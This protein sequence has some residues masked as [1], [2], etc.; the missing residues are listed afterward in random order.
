MADDELLEELLTV[1][2]RET[3]QGLNLT[4]EDLC[5]DR[6][7]LARELEQ[8]IGELPQK[9]GL[10][11]DAF[12]TLSCANLDSH[13]EGPPP[14]VPSAPI[15]PGYEV[16]GELGRGG[17]GVVYQARQVKLG[18]VVALKMILSGAHAGTADLARFRTEAEA[19]ARLQHP[20]IVQIY[21]V[22]EY[23]GQPFFSLEFCASG[24]LEKKLGRTP[25]PPKEAAALVETLARAMQTAHDKGVIHRDLKPANV[26]LAEDGT[27]KIT[28]F[29]LAKKLDEVGQTMTGAV[30]GTPPYMAPEQAGG[31][32]GPAGPAV[33]VYAL[34]AILYE[35]L[36]GRPPFKAATSIDTIMQVLSH[37]PVPPRQL[38]P[39]TP[40][41]LETVCLKCLQK[42][43][44]KRYASAH[45]L[46]EDLRRFQ[47]DEPILARPVGRAE[48]GWRWCR[49]NPAV[50]ASLVAVAIA[51][52]A[53]S[54]VSVSF[55]LRAAERARTESA[56]KQDAERAHRDAQRQ[57][58]DLCVGSG[59][60]AAKENDHGLALLW[61][62]RATQLAKDEPE[63]EELNRIRV[64]NWLRQVCLPEGAFTVPG[65]RERE[66]KFRTFQFS[67]DGNYLLVI[68]TSAGCQ[69]WD[70]PA[71][72]LVPLPEPAAKSAAAAWQ[73]KSGLLA[74]AGGDGQIRL[75]AP[76]ELRPVGEAITAGEATV[77]AFSQDGQRLAWGGPE[78]AR[79][80]D[81]GRMDYITP[82]L[83][84]PAPVV[85]VAFS[86]ASELLATSARDGK[87]RVFR[88]GSAEEKPLFPPVNHFLGEY[89]NQTSDEPGRVPP[90]FAAAD[91]ILL[92]VERMP[93]GPYALIRRSAFT[94]EF[95][96]S[97][98]VPPGGNYLSGYA[99][100][101]QG[102]RAV[103][104]WS[105]SARLFDTATGNALAALPSG[106]TRFESAAFDSDGNT[107]VTCGMDGSIRFWSLQEQPK[108][109]NL[110]SS[111]S[112]AWNPTATARL[113][114][115]GDG[116]HVAVALWDGSVCLWRL[117]DKS[118]LLCYSLP[119]GTA[120]LSA[121]SPDGQ[122]VL[123]RG[124]SYRS[125]TLLATQV[126]Q[127]EAGEA[128]GPRIV[129]GGILLDAAVS[130][131]G[132]RLAT[133]CSTARTPD[134]RNRRRFELDGK[135]GNVHL[136]DWKTGKRLGKPIPTPGEPRGLAFRP[137]GRTLAAVCA[138]NYVVLVDTET[139]AITHGLDPGVRTREYGNANQWWSNGE[140]RFSPDG[141]FLVTWEMSPHVHVWAP[142][143][144]QLLHT[145]LHTDRVGHVCFNPTDPTLLA[146][147]SWDNSA[148]IWNLDTGELVVRLQHPA[149]VTRVQFSPDGQELIT[150]CSDGTLRVWDR[151]TGKLMDGIPLQSDWTMDF[152]FV[153]DR[154]W[155]ITLGAG[156]LQ[157]TDWQT[158]TPVGPLW[159]F[160]PGFNLELSVPSGGRRAVVAGFAEKLVAYDLEKA[161]TPVS[162]AVEALVPLAELAAGRRILSEG[163]VVP[164]TSAEWVE[165]WQEL[166]A[167]GAGRSWQD[168]LTEVELQPVAAGLV[169]EAVAGESKR[170]VF[171]GQGLE[172]LEAYKQALSDAPDETARSQIMDEL[173]QF[174]V[175][176]AVQILNG[177]WQ[178]AAASYSRQ[179]E[180]DSNADSLAW[181]AAPALWAYVGSAERHR[182]SCRK[183]CEHFLDSG[184]PLDIE[185]CLKL[186]LAM[187]NGPD[188]PAEKVQEFYASCDTLAGGMRAWFLGTR[189]WMECR[190]GNYADARQH[191]EESLA[192]EKEHASHDIKA[193][194]LA[195]RSLI[196]AKQNDVAQARASL[197]ELYAVMSQSQKISWKADG[198]LD[199]RTILNGATVVH[200]KLI[201]EIIRRETEVL[202][203]S[204][205]R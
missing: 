189:A 175:L 39:R 137:D 92:T 180:H 62:A 161:V 4:A 45:E 162:A 115:S 103:A 59:M 151:T 186:M 177:D 67:P 176:A 60:V 192:L 54:A 53:G 14:S 204:A 109:H 160:K 194:A 197:S 15:V 26:L 63:Q 73:P 2:Q 134:E 120:T 179:I 106:R 196:Y 125:G 201:P 190:K 33:D 168:W 100:N 147:G 202:I 12:R 32:M 72:R 82:L 108:D 84:H 149:W 50:A 102:D 205:A 129:P 43:P 155:L 37:Y 167:R 95:L 46:A 20:N 5:R 140:A 107:L 79:V 173:D 69:V 164:L 187:E 24:S 123:P 193:L 126:Y 121:L 138:D 87:A 13:P 19:I 89:G 42:E 97:S 49:R 105:D 122:F 71:A 185:H 156:D 91:K 25:L 48:R 52:L 133:A 154:R 76:P 58:I 170:L 165:R 119:T 200:D 22:G 77:V 75:F 178:G 17:M 9:N 96:S 143:Q 36:A 153:A 144:G 114:L 51:L 158:K 184:S 10:H 40:H 86:R 85:T 80:W 18:R 78:G 93:E 152:G 11:H 116:R 16:L 90:R 157:V 99:V 130:P 6:P 27:P 183:M 136:W 166:S 124:T 148:R 44:S 141:R 61:F 198:L 118:P 135:G 83:A 8:R 30:M 171:R 28:D 112:P 38:Q 31:R 65:F 57:L 127:A 191:V 34:G 169:P 188:V 21:E 142:D 159:N 104:L 35:C 55:G 56:A 7:E 23:L 182:E 113:S 47:A 163:R 146:T 98:G 88:V 111:A 64:A 68:S 117:P 199:G 132:S 3:E 74:V 94:G 150:S 41:D 29:G 172:A 195:V 203:Q 110:V 128:A 139:N 1:W 81:F 174:G 131:D 70:R 101:S 181:M 66:D 145:L